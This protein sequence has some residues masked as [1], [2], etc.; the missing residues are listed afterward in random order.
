MVFHR[1][2][3][4]TLASFDKSVKFIYRLEN[5]LKSH[6]LQKLLEYNKLNH[7]A[8]RF[9]ELCYGFDITFKQIKSFPFTKRFS[10]FSMIL[11]IVNGGVDEFH[12]FED[13]RMC[14]FAV[15]YLPSSRNT[16]APRSFAYVFSER[17]LDER[18]AYKPLYYT[19]WKT[20]NITRNIRYSRQSTP[21]EIGRCI[22][23]I[24]MIRFWK[25]CVFVCVYLSFVFYP[26]FIILS[27]F[28]WFN[29][30]HLVCLLVNVPYECWT[31]QSV[32]SVSITIA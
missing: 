16:I 2:C 25:L 17:T 29:H 30:N 32:I 11:I 20:Y 4:S 7:S 31:Y 23:Y 14:S 27:Y 15:F 8:Q 26:S 6:S 19:T 18:R 13:W 22:L 21:F 12:C 5:T 24:F 28:V 10:I 9:F 3:L 1:V